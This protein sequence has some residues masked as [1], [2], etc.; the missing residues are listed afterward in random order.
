MFVFSVVDM[1]FMFVLIC[2]L[3]MTLG[4]EFKYVV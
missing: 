4:S 1:C 2:A 3:F